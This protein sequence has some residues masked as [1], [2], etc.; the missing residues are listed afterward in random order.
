[1]RYQASSFSPKG[2]STNPSG[3][4][5][6][7]MSGS[8]PGTTSGS[9][10][11]VGNRPGS[12]GPPGGARSSLQDEFDALSRAG[13]SRSLPVTPRSSGGIRAGTDVSQHGRAT[14]GGRTSENEHGTLFSDQQ[15]Q[16]RGHPNTSMADLHWQH[17]GGATEVGQLSASDL[18][19]L[20]DDDGFEDASPSAP[21][22]Q[23]PQTMSRW[24][25]QPN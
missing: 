10:R 24:G 20:T 23:L 25:F 16:R 15:M 8:H 14:A 3:S 4:R 7:T 1:M 5:P 6:G 2:S 9:S 19:G 18:A 21:S 13:T 17:Q 22:T 11:A 12:K